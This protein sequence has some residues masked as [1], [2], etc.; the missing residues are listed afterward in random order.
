MSL[1]TH[2]E[3]EMG[4]LMYVLNMIYVLQIRSNFFL[5]VH[6]IVT[7]RYCTSKTSLAGQTLYLFATRGLDGSGDLGA[8][9]V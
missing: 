5:E 4:I 7:S 2:L 8:I 1:Y 3:Y 6:E 9:F